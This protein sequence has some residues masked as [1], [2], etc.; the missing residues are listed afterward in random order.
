M[1]TNVLMMTPLPTVEEAAALFQHEEAQRR[2]YKNNVKMEIDNSA[3]FAGPKEGDIAPAPTCN[4]CKRKG[5]PRDKCWKVIGYPDDHP[6][7]LKYPEKSQSFKLR[8]NYQGASSK[9][10]RSGA[11]KNK[12][13]SHNRQGKL[14]G[15]VMMGEGQTD[16]GG[17]IT[18]TTQ[19][20]EQLMNNQKGKG[21]SY[22]ETEDE[23]EANFAGLSHQDY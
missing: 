4:V 12:Q 11:H 18:L 21:V 8:N 2:N 19:Q 10:Y 3:F 17:S 16:V 13:S 6:V 9:G 7:S 23:L 22:P 1:R 14:A 15:N 5:H 20:F